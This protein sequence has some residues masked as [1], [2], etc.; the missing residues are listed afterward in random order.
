MF[1]NRLFERIQNLNKIYSN[2]NRVICKVGGLDSQDQ[3]RSRSRTSL[4]SRPV[5][6]T[7]RDQLFEMSRS[8]LS[9]ET[10]IK[11][12][13]NRDFIAQKLS[14]FVE[15]SFLNCRD[16]SRQSRPVFKTCRDQLL[17][18]SRSRVSIETMSRQIETPKPSYLPSS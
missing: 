11:I 1:K 5:F 16:Q 2:F 7:C 12:E 4:A 8:R 17:E 6:K 3:S 18:V 10:K 13:T 15:M 9:I 14:R